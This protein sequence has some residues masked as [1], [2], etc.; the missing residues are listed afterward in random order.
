[1]KISVFPDPRRWA[2]SSSFSF[3]P[4]TTIETHPFTAGDEIR[5]LPGP[6]QGALGIEQAISA[7]QPIRINAKDVYVII[8]NWTNGT[9]E[10]NY[11]Y[12]LMS[13]D[14]NLLAEP[15]NHDSCWLKYF[16]IFSSTQDNS[17]HFSN[18]LLKNAQEIEN[19]KPMIFAASSSQ[20]GHWMADTLPILLY[21]L[22]ALTLPGSIFCSPFTEYQKTVCQLLCDASKLRT[23][24]LF[25]PMLRD[26]KI[27]IIKFRSLDVITSFSVRNKNQFTRQFVKTAAERLGIRSEP[28]LHKG[29]YLYR[30]NVN[31]IQRVNEE[32]KIVERLQEIGFSIFKTAR[33]TFEETLTQFLSPQL[34]INPFG[35]GN[36]HFN[37]TASDSAKLIQLLPISYQQTTVEKTL[38][39]AIYMVPRIKSTNF[40]LCEQLDSSST[41]EHSEILINNYLMQEIERVFDCQTR[42]E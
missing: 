26:E 9:E 33:M 30:G 21:A 6:I 34:F 36:T 8:W 13:S 12:F 27:R 23:A 20:F 24:T 5:W 38:G 32:D 31:G 39:S 2:E 18:E 41:S 29:A 15:P 19:S 10:F 4:L 22:D 16:P 40:Y 3:A 25:H 14:G 17:L 7:Q 37:L 42:M 35:S 11:K 1:M 28:A